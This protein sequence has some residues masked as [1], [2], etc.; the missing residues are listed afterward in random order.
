MLLTLASN[1][2][3]FPFLLAFAS[4]VDAARLLREASAGPGSG[5]WGFTVQPCRTTF[6][7]K[8]EPIWWKE[9]GSEGGRAFNSRHECIVNRFV[10]EVSMN[11]CNQWSMV[12]AGAIRCIR[13][14]RCFDAF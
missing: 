4:G 1:S 3:S 6:G 2:A 13:C 12:N 14:S 7:R 11:I 8:L 5:Y 9:G 10:A